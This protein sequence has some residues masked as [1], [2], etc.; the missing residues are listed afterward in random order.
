MKNSNL[1]FYMKPTTV[2]SDIVEFESEIGFESLINILLNEKLPEYFWKLIYS[3]FKYIGVS[4]SYDNPF[5]K[6][7][8]FVHLC[9]SSIDDNSPP[10]LHPIDE[11]HESHYSQSALSE[12]KRESYRNIGN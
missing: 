4:I 6:P 9:D 10:P 3:D 7:I 2:V 11:Y 5:H 12:S 1:N 8:A